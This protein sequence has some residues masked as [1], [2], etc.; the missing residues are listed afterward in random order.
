MSDKKKCFKCGEIKP[1]SAFYKHKKMADGRVNKCKECNKLDVRNNYRANIDYYKERE[2]VRAALPHR[3]EARKR[4]AKTDEGKSS[5]NRAKKAWGK[6]NPIKRGAAIVVGNAVRDGKLIK[7]DSC[8]K[9]SNTPSSLHAHHD[10]YAFPLAVRWLCPGCHTA[11]H[12][13]NGEAANG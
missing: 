13:E 2:K 9:C 6:R 1:L 3:V 10:D 7:P 4:Y 8:S 5:G 12:K 11:W